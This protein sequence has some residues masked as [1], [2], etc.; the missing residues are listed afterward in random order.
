[1]RVPTFHPC[2]LSFPL[3]VPLFVSVKKMIISKV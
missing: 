2:I 3:S 1:L